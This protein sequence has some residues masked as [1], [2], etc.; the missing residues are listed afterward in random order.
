MEIEEVKIG[1]KKTKKTYNDGVEDTK[2]I[3]LDI[4]KT[5]EEEKAT[6]DFFIDFKEEFERELKKLLK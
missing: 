3:V 4:I 2:K 6:N 5:Y 1:T